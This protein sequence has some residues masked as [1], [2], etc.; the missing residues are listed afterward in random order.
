VIDQHQEAGPAAL[1]PC[2]FDSS[3]AVTGVTM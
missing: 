3:G 1:A 2:T